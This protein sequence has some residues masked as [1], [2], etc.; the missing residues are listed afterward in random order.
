VICHQRVPV[1][2]LIGCVLSPTALIAQGSEPESPKETIAILG[3]GDMGDSFG[4]RLASLGYTIVYGS[5][6]P[7]SERIGDL[8]A[9]TGAN[10]TAATSDVA[11]R[12][13]DIVFLALPWDPME[14]VI[15]SLGPMKDKIIV[16]LSWPASELAE[17]GFW[18]M[19]IKPSGAEVIQGW[20]P[21]AMV[22]KAFGTIGSYVIDDPSLAGGPVS[23]PI[24]SDH[25]SAKETVARIAAEL[26]LDP[27]DAGPLRM[28]AN[29]EAMMEL[30]MVPHTQGRALGWEFYFQRS[31]YWFCDPYSG[32]EEVETGQ[33]PD[34]LDLADIPMTQPAPEAC[35]K[36]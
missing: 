21:E 26:G 11:A 24:A 12:Q 1:L 14:Q 27:V 7:E 3:T 2:L 36:Q 29:L 17:D 33:T 18:R 30:Y 22:V 25:R 10:S 35:K 28:A 16:D 15:K 13:A 20:V 32:G 8:I 23:I 4:P 34:Q 19:T 9:R 31:N 5:R 6:S